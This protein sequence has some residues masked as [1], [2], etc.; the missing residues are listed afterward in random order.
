LPLAPMPSPPEP[1]LGDAEANLVTGVIKTMAQVLEK[2]AYL[3]K[4]TNELVKETYNLTQEMVKTNEIMLKNMQTLMNITTKEL[5]GTMKSMN[6]M[7]TTLVF[8]QQLTLVLM[9]LMVALLAFVA[10]R[11][12]VG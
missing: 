11:L 12:L 6:A 2:M 10:W 8:Y 5:A 7:M 4:E 1:P 3:L 9:V